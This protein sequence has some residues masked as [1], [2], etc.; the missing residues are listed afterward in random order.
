MY[1]SKCRNGQKLAGAIWY[2]KHNIMTLIVAFHERRMADK[3][4]IDIKA[5]NLDVSVIGQGV[6]LNFI[7]SYTE[8][9]WYKFETTFKSDRI[10]I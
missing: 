1:I 3:R 4:I 7:I 10:F 6:S 8:Q 2:N 5:F 9:V